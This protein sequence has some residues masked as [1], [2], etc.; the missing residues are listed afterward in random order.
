MQVWN[1]KE[2]AGHNVR[3]LKEKSQVFDSYHAWCTRPDKLY[4]YIRTEHSKQWK[5]LQYWTTNKAKFIVTPYTHAHIFTL[6][7]KYISYT[8]STGMSFLCGS[9]VVWTQGMVLGTEGIALPKKAI[10]QVTGNPTCKG[11]PWTG[12]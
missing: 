3:L 12:R 2:S 1:Q 6:Q 4:V 11:E 8:N 9:M 10:L 7:S 5:V